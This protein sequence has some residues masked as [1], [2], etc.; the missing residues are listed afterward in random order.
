[1]MHEEHFQMNGYQ[2]IMVRQMSPSQAFHEG[3]SQVGIICRG[4]K[5]KIWDILSTVLPRLENACRGNKL[6]N[7]HT[8]SKS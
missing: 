3:S 6:D 4:K 2:P 7:L 8:G 5:I 1:M